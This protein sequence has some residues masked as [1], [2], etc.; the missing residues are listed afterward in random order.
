LHEDLINAH[1]AIQKAM[2]TYQNTE[3]ANTSTLQA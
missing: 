2:D 3:R 1:A